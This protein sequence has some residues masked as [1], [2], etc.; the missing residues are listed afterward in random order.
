MEGDS[1]PEQTAW[2]QWSGVLFVVASILEWT[3][4]LLFTVD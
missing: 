3:D 4:T 1:H 2:W